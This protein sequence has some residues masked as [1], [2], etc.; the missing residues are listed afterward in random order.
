MKKCY[1]KLY[2]YLPLFI[3]CFALLRYS[4]VN[5]ATYPLASGRVYRAWSQ[6]NGS[7]WQY[8]QN[9]TDFVQADYPVNV[10]RSDT[11][12]SRVLKGI[13][14]VGNPSQGSSNYTVNSITNIIYQFR[15]QNGDCWNDGH[16]SSSIN[17]TDYVPT[18]RLISGNDVLSTQTYASY[19]CQEEIAGNGY[20]LHNFYFSGFSTTDNTAINGLDFRWGDA[21]NVPTTQLGGI[22]GVG[23]TTEVSDRDWAGTIVFMGSAYDYSTSNDPNAVYQGTIINQNNTMINQNQQIINNQNAAAQQDQQD[24]DNIQDT[25]DNAQNSADNAQDQNEQATASLLDTM[26]ALFTALGTPA[27]D[28]IVNADLGNIDLGQINYCSGKPAAFEPIINSVCIMIMAIPIYLIARDL[29][30][31]FIY[32]TSYAQGGDNVR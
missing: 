23:T 8:R 17:T 5:A 28:C 3:F 30:L 24:R 15:Q 16:S 13:R 11:D 7:T 27:T 12:W 18:L 20:I 6:V 19:D 21:M 14:V 2:L 9:Y 31:R 26:N 32:L 25:A 22:A 1:T 4:S 29:M 10:L